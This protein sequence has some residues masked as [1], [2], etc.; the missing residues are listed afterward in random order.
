M[1]STLEKSIVYTPP[2][3]DIKGISIAIGILI[4]FEIFWYHAIFQIDLGK[5]H[6][7]DVIGT[8][9]I[10]EFL[11]TGLFITCHDAIHGAISVNVSGKIF[12]RKDL[13]SNHV[14]FSVS[15]IEP[16]DWNDWF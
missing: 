1:E 2:K 11:Y 12:I 8:F 13:S 7:F 6:W 9:I 3:S 10:L 4:L 15:T 16:C 14:W 5:T